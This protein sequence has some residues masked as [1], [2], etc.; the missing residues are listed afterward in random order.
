MPEASLGTRVFLFAGLVRLRVAVVALAV[1]FAG[2]GRQSVRPAGPVLL[3]YGG[4]PGSTRVYDLEL[5]LRGRITMA[6][7]P[8][9]VVLNV[10]GKL[11]E[12]VEGIG[13]GGARTVR[14]NVDLDPPEIN[15]V[16]MDASGMPRSAGAL[17]LRGPSGEL[18]PAPDAPAPGELWGWMAPFLGGIFPLLSPEPVEEGGKWEKTHSL[19]SGAG[20][21]DITFTGSVANAERVRGAGR[22]AWLSTSGAI[23]LP[24]PVKKAGLEQFSL[25]YDGTMKF[26]VD[27]GRVIESFQSGDV[28]LKGGSGKSPVE[29]RAKY[30]LTMKP[31][32]TAQ[33]PLANGE[34]RSPPA[35]KP[36]AA[37]A[38][39]EFRSPPAPKPEAASANGERRQRRVKLADRQIRHRL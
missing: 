25:T 30:S 11:R 6:G 12:T 35:P 32:P 37:S 27:E 23:T 39:G 8:Q 24:E 15:G 17:F 34:L 33:R 13:P 14:L 36:E 19:S 18:L 22:I 21:L 7:I 4:E 9:L 3:A 28:R 20:K 38:N 1:I 10:K 16:P 26:A 29:A 2:C 31:A 5:V